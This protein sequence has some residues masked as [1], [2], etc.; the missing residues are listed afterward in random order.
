MVEVTAKCSNTLGMESIVS[1]LA[2]PTFPNRD[3]EISVSIIDLTHYWA[4]NQL[5]SVYSRVSSICL[6]VNL[7]RLL[8]LLPFVAQ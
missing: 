3:N 5:S 2:F 4:T 7:D 1:E 6:V 8:T